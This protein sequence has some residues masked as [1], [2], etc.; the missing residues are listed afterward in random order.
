MQVDAV[1]CVMMFKP[2]ENRCCH[3]KGYSF[4][5]P[6]RHSPS[7]NATYVSPLATTSR[8]YIVILLRKKLAVGHDLE[9]GRNHQQPKREVPAVTERSEP[10]THP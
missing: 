5:S 7:G 1:I 9:K 3:K 2:E 10:G 4:Q 6:H 8:A